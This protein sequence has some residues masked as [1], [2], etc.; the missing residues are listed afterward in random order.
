M[1]G[2]GVTKTCDCGRESPDDARFC[3][4]CGS[5]FV[6][7]L[8]PL[9]DPDSGPDP[10]F[11]SIPL[12]EGERRIVTI[13]MSDLS[14]YT[15]LGERFDP[16][17]VAE[18]M[19]TIKQEGT[20]IIES[21]GGVVNQFIGDEI[22]SLF[23][24]PAARDD[25]ARRAV[26]AA[27]ALHERVTRLGHE[28]AGGGDNTLSMHSGVQTGLL[29]AHVNDG[30]NGVYE[31]TGDAINTAARLLSLAD[32]GD[33]I[34]GDETMRLVE[35]LVEVDDVGHHAVRGKARPISAFRV[36]SASPERSRFEA[37]E[38]VGLTPFTGRD[39]EVSRLL[40]RARTAFF[41]RSAVVVIEGEAG[42]G[43]S[44]LCHEFLRRLAVRHPDV[45][46]L[47]GRCQTYGSITPYL[48]F[49]QLVR[50]SLGV[51]RNTPTAEL[52]ELVPDAVARLSPDL[53]ANTPAY[54]H[55]L[56][57]L[58]S[59]ELPPDWR[60]DHLPEMLQRACVDLVRVVAATRPCV[61]KLDD[62]HWADPASRL[63]LARL[64]EGL[65]RMHALVLVAQRPTDDD[66][67][68][69]ISDR[70]VLDAFDMTQTRQM[71]CARFGVGDVQDRLVERVHERTSGNPFFVEEVCAALE[72]SHATAIV[73]DRLTEVQDLDFDVIPTTIQ[74][75]VLGRIDLLPATPK[76]MLRAA[77]VIGREFRLD[78][79]VR[80]FPHTDLTESLQLAQDRG[81]IESMPDGDAK[82]Y[83]FRHVITQSVVY[84]SVLLR[85]RADLHGA[86]AA[87]IVA[88]QTDEEQ[89]LQK[90]VEALAHHYLGAGDNARSIEY[91]EAAG[92]KAAGRFAIPEA[93]S[94]FRHALDV[95]L[96]D[97]DDVEARRARARL[98]VRWAET[99]V[100]APSQD[101]V[102]LLQRVIGETI[103]DGDL[104]RAV[105]L[106]YWSTWIQH[107]VG[108][109]SDAE[110]GVRMMLGQL[111]DDAG[112]PVVE[113]LHLLLGMILVAARRPDE[114]L[115]HLESGIADR[116]ARFQEG[117][118]A[119]AAS[120]MFVYSL[121]QRAV[122]HADIG[123]VDEAR[124]A[125]EYALEVN[126]LAGQR[127]TEGSVQI[128]RCIAQVMIGDW[129]EI[130]SA[131]RDIR[132]LDPVLVTPHVD[133]VADI[134]DTFASIQLRTGQDVD[135]L[136]RAVAAQRTSESL[137][138]LSLAEAL[139]ATA[140]ADAGRV[141]DA[142]RHAQASRERRRHD[143]VYGDDLAQATLL[144]ISGLDGD[145][146]QQR[147][148]EDLQ[149]PAIAG[150]ERSRAML[151]LALAQAHAEAL[152][153][154]NALLRLDEAIEQMQRL[155]LTGWLDRAIGL[156]E[157]LRSS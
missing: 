90:N 72:V 41:D 71:I 65:G 44:R 46:V 5:R 33:V 7:D 66:G 77:S 127:L 52:L 106:G 79:L 142:R 25:D 139:L 102:A 129:T 145:A 104:R 133:R 92:E 45:A 108:Q 40:D 3:S 39:G 155:G 30:R 135:R 10:T 16:E 49:V 68:L 87:G 119:A 57:A 24:L 80:L 111:G 36:R 131:V 6:Q 23:G 88:E 42:S 69:R 157:L 35:G 137:L 128:C 38:D 11:T 89:R 63:T 100:Y 141:D 15:S 28:I 153:L 110:A 73:D 146:L 144:R 132:Q 150:S 9:G 138:A 148:A 143:D 91:L 103:E 29:I 130:R 96:L 84:D 147:F 8:D 86:I 47:Q 120:G 115:G 70:L 34:I 97:P 19:R 98:A 118:T 81:L 67:E 51:E 156:R 60:G 112:G 136:A 123:R 125:G 109:Q 32:S 14:G 95:S 20:E 94:R 122:A 140:M 48:P 56:S 21:Y 17:L 1:K 59:N 113:A 54:L 116:L 149:S 126:R 101:Q 55:L 82:R 13:L 61:V 18:V 93:R 37:S 31:L 117:D 134:L 64:V 107:S 27:L 50:E 62:W 121:A 58:T 43:K 26:L 99:C 53:V 75:A 4:G 76:R 85:S 78:T 114:A 105:T 12:L 22:V 152:E 2:M 154:D 124:R 83:R 151:T 74:A